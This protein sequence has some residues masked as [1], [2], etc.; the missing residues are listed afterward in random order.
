MH[1]LEYLQSPKVECRGVDRITEVHQASITGSG[2][3]TADFAAGYS[4]D[5]QI[6]QNDMNY[7][8]NTRI[9]VSEVGAQEYTVQTLV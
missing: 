6:Y 4:L 2:S 7:T 8:G 1:S 3:L 5:F 9:A